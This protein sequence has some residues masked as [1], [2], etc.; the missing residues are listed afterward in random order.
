R[1]HRTAHAATL[2]SL[3]ALAACGGEGNDERGEAPSFEGPSGS[4]APS[5]PDDGVAPV[6]DEVPA[7][8]DSNPVTPSEAPGDLPLAPGEEPSA[9]NGSGAAPP[10]GDDGPPST[11][12]PPS[13]EP[14]PD[15]K[16]TRLN[17]S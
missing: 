3:L 17:S 9:G 8:V 6:V 7:P 1:R 14:P 5:A 4:P 15:R 16:S 12:P 13:D 11:E 2:L 10:P